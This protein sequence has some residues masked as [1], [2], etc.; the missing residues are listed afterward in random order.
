MSKPI[1]TEY[2]AITG[3]TVN[4]EM[5]PEEISEHEAVIANSPNLPSVE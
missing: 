1:V 3:V 5:T 2:D 4:R